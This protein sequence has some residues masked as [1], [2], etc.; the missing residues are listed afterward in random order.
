MAS[1]KRKAERDL[2]AISASARKC[3]ESKTPRPA[4]RTRKPKP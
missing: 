1:V 2:S 4:A 3:A